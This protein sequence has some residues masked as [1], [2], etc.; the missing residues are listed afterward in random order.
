[1]ANKFSTLCFGLEAK[2]M[3]SDYEYSETTPRRLKTSWSVCTGV[4]F[5]DKLYWFI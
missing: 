5:F 4:K 2:L 1:M 3:I